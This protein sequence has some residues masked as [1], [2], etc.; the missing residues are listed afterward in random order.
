VQERRLFF[1]AFCVSLGY[2][3]LFPEGR[4]ITTSKADVD[5]LILINIIMALVFQI[6]SQ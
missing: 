3:L 2:L 4:F 5:D 1:S 6:P